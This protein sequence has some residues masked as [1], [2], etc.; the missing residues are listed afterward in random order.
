MYKFVLGALS[1]LLFV[2]TG[3]A[4][5]VGVDGVITELGGS[6]VKVDLYAVYDDA[7]DVLVE[8]TGVNIATDGSWNQDPAGWDPADTNDPVFDS[9]LNVETTGQLFSDG[10]VETLV[11]L[12][13][14]GPQSSSA[15]AGGE[16]GL[17][18]FG[19]LI[20]QFVI[21]GGTTFSYNGILESE[22]SVAGTTSSD[23]GAFSAT[24]P[25]PGAIA[26]LALAG[27]TARK[28]RR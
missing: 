16:D 24:L 7:D 20:G 1:A 6:R 18:G 26:L 19:V 21:S 9:F 22:N 4:D 11:G 3:S 2:G 27:L 25:G 23:P 8:Q 14:T 5:V 28:R 17:S 13:D 10:G 15:F 12:P